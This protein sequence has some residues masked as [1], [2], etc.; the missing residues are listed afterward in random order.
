MT[1]VYPPS[2]SLNL[3]SKIVIS[4]DGIQLFNESA[5]KKGAPADKSF[6]L[7]LFLDFATIA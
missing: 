1:S 3:P 4:S 6:E 5:G 7:F 2:D